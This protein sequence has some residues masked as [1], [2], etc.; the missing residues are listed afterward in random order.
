MQTGRQIS[1]SLGAMQSRMVANANAPRTLNTGFRGQRG[2]VGMLDNIN[3]TGK[4][5]TEYDPKS[6]A[7]A[8]LAK[9]IVTI[10]KTIG[11][12]PDDYVL[13]YRGAPKNQTT[14]NSGDF[15]TTNKQLAKDYAGDGVVISQ[16]VKKS[17][18]LDDI[19]E[20][21]G[22][23]YIYRKL[24]RPLTEFE[25]AHLLAQQRAALLVSQGGLGLAPDNTAMD[26]A[27]AMGFDTDVY[28]GTN[29]DISAFDMS[30]VGSNI[31]LPLDA[32]RGVYTAKDAEVASRYSK[33][34]G[35][36]IIPLMQKSSDTAL[37]NRKIMATL[38]PSSIRSRFAAFDP[39]NRDSS[40]LLAQSAKFVPATTLGAYMANEKRK[41][42]QKRK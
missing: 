39:F 30:K 37:N 5:F 21:L 36:N 12:S 3:P 35:S 23:E 32:P 41:D 8:I 38:N 22:E 28:H 1:N 26:R 15:V 42:E 14:L 7:N 40:N 25:Q 11:G 4:V 33:G 10:D 9:N 13:V 2:A 19:N 29:A 34:D 27:R 17:E 6:R 18:I 20:P 31:V 24:E 16:K